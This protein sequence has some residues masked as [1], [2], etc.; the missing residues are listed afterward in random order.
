MH[1]ACQKVEVKGGISGIVKDIEHKF[2]INM[3]NLFSIF[4]QV[5]CIQNLSVTQ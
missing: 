5:M 1:E 3:D 4:W 2:G